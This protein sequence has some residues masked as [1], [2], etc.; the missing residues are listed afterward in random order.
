MHRQVFI[1]R[2]A[3]VADED[4]FERALFILRKVVSNRDL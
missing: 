3:H 4:T 1:G 2:G